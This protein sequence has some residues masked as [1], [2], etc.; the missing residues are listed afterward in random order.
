MATW[1]MDAQECSQNFGIFL[2]FLCEY[3][4]KRTLC[5][6]VPR[7]RLREDLPWV[8]NPV[9]L[10]QSRGS[11]QQAGR[12][13]SVLKKS[14][15]WG[16]KLC[17]AMGGNQSHAFNHPLGLK[18]RRGTMFG[19]QSSCL[20]HARSRTPRPIN[21]DA[22][23]PHTGPGVALRLLLRQRVMKAALAGTAFLSLGGVPRQLRA[24]FLGFC[25]CHVVCNGCS[26]PRVQG[27]GP[28]GGFTV[29]LEPGV[30]VAFRL[31]L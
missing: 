3:P 17:R 24:C 19:P 8:H 23:T 9:V 6:C 28:W 12:T 11:V 2:K 30:G 29:R 7:L 13:A 15:F 25:G 20:C 16:S 27:I 1:F 5:R 18:K 21:P 31:C 22:E 10:Q 26:K 4:G 14:K